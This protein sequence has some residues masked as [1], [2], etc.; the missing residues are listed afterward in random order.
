METAVGDQH[1]PSTPI[2]D[3][4]ALYQYA[5]CGYF[6]ISPNGDI[7]KINNTLLTWL[8]YREEELLGSKFMALLS[9]GGQMHFEM[10]FKPLA[11]VNKSVKEL[12]YEV[13]RKDGSVMPVLLN[14][15]SVQGANGRML[16][17]NGV[18]IDITERKNY[19]KE[20][21]LAK[22]TAEREKNRLEFMADLVPEIIW[23]AT[24][25][26][27][28]DYVNARFC[29]YFDCTGKDTRY[30]FVLSKLHPDDLRE[31]IKCWY[32]C[33][34][35]GADLLKEVRLR[36]RV[37][38]YE[39]HLL[40]AAKFLDEQGHL[41]NW[42]GSCTNIED[43]VKALKKK[44]E[45]ISIASHELKTPI[46]SLTAVM[47]LLERMKNNLQHTMVPGLIEKANRSAVKINALVDDLLN[48]SQL[49]QGQLNLK[50]TTFNLAG[51]I[52]DCVHHIRMAGDYQI[53]TEGDTGIII[54]ADENRVEQV[55]T[56]FINNAIKY[57]PLSKQILVRLTKSP[58]HVLIE[59]SD[60]G[61]GI[62][63]EKVPHLFDRYYQV[64]SK[65]IKYTG[66]GLGLYIS[67]EIVKKHG[68][69]IGVNSR[70][71]EGSTFWFTLPVNETN[72]TIGTL[73]K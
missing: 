64:E 1:S 46:T 36:N 73:T 35:K 49:T 63:A 59:V 70:I 56:N 50:I 12:S 60:K 53:I 23:T 29:Q 4:E 30:A 6:S 5:P 33:I 48:A 26:G 54:S 41:T 44:D 34:L 10:F 25:K 68:G 14:A 8:G 72:G 58:G 11:T 69:D 18:L 3:L 2:I 61:P 42:F 71:G 40:K 39:W 21:L 55:I 7:I 20:L 43:H 17:I 45:F 38:R 67:A 37:G 28:I 51:L 32:N 52:G 47:Q 31:L 19:E 22:R 16:A 66:L 24:A 15:S 62:P 13:L 65:G 9:K 57:A 27:N